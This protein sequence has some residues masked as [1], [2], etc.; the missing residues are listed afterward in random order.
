MKIL[1]VDDDRDILNLVF[2]ALNA[3]GDHD[4]DMAASGPEALEIIAASAAPFDCF[5][6]DI[7]MPLMTGIALCDAIRARKEYRFSPVIMVTATSDKDHIDRAFSAGATDY[8]TKPFD[9]FDLK[10]RITLAEKSAFQARQLADDVFHLNELQEELKTENFHALEDAIPIDDVDGVLRV[11]AFESYL[12]HMNRTQFNRTRL[13]SVVTLNIDTIYDLCTGR[14]FADQVADIAEAIADALD[15]K[16]PFITYL[17]RGV[18][19]LAVEAELVEDVGTL[20]EEVEAA[21]LS[22]GM[23]Y[24]NGDPVDVQVDVLEITKPGSYFSSENKIMFIEDLVRSWG[25][26]GRNAMS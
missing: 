4:V 17:G 3:L 25:G 15:G 1:I 5:L 13:L 20:L 16:A 18:Y 10:H 9:I 22:L 21:I 14:E 23:I 7:Q 12:K 11:H 26:F 19:I 2:Q 24:R 8:L 6:L